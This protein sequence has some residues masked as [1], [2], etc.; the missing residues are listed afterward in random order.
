MNHVAGQVLTVER[1]FCRRKMLVFGSELTLHYC[2]IE[3]IFGQVLSIANKNKNTT[4]ENKKSL[5]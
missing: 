4:E 1:Q 2:D 3:H 5:I